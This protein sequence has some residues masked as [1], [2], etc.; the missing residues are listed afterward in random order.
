ML[1]EIGLLVFGRRVILRLG[2]T[3]LM[4]VGAAGAVLRWPLMGLTPPLWLLIPLQTL[5]AATFASTYLGSVEFIGRAV[6]EEYRIV[7]MTLVSTLGVGAM[8]GVATIVA[9]YLFDAESPFAAYALMGGMGAAGLVMAV[10]LSRRW[11]GGPLR[12]LPPEEEGSPS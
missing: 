5:H 11:D 4:L 8:T 12:A 2:P 1:A 3:G 7:A 10:Q 9:G 6:P